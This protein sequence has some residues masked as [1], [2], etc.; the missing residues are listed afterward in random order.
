MENSYK[1]IIY[2]KKTFREI[3]LPIEKTSVVIGTEKHCDFRFNREFFFDSFEFTVKKIPNAAWQIRCGSNLYISDISDMKYT[4]KS[5]N[6]GDSYSLKYQS[7]NHEL[8]KIVF[9][10]NYD[11]KEYNFNR[12]IDLNSKK[13]ISF[14][15][16][17]SCNVCLSDSLLSNGKVATLKKSDQGWILSDTGSKHGVFIN[18]TKILR[19]ETV[20]DYD[21]FSILGFR[22]F[23]KDNILY[24]D[25]SYPL[26]LNSLE[27]F[28]V[29]RIGSS[30]VYPK[31]NRNTRLKYTVSTEK[32]PI[33]DPEKEPEKPKSNVLTS[34]LP[35]VA[36]LI[37]ILVIRGG[38][39]SGEG[40]LLS[41]LS[42]NSFIL[43]SAATMCLGMVT[44]VF[45]AI[46][47][48]KD[49]YKSLKKREHVYLKY[50]E[51]KGKEVD[52][53]RQQEADLLNDIYISLDEELQQVKD[54]SGDLFDKSPEDDDFLRV[55]LGLGSIESKRQ[56][57]YKKKE[58]LETS[59]SL[60]SK[61][62]DLY[63]E[64]K[65]V[66]N[67]PVVANFKDVNALGVVGDSAHL[68]Q[69]MKNMIVD[70]CVRHHYNDVK[71]FV[72]VEESKAENFKWV[73]WFQN[74]YN[75]KLDIR[76][77][78]CNDESKNLL[79]EYLYVE[80]SKRENEN[81][82]YPYTIVMVF[83]DVG[84]KLHP[85]S[86]YIQKA[87][88]FGFTFVFF[89]NYKE[90]LPQGC[91]EIILLN[92]E[93]GTGKLIPAK[94]VNSSVNFKYS[95]ISDDNALYISQRL[96]SVYCE[97]VSLEN[98][99]TKNITLFELLNIIDVYDLDL[100]KRWK[101]S[102]VSET[103][104]APLGVKTK[105]KIVSLDIHE[106]AHGPH[107][108]VAGT[109]GSGKSEILQTYILSM[110][111]LYHPYEVGFVIIDFKGGG[112]AN[113]FKNLPHLIG[114]ITNI[115]GREID[116][117]L[118]SIKAELEKRQI[119]FSEYDVNNINSYIKL[120]KSGKTSIP[121]PHLI[122]VVDEFAELKAEQ[123]EFMKELIS[124]ARI[125]RSL[126]VHLILATQKPA[127]QVNEQIWSNSKFKLCLK[128]QTKEDSNEVL[129]SPLAAEI[130]EPGRAYLQVGNN[131][132]F[133]LFQSAY[134]GAL[135]QNDVDNIGKEYTINCVELS[136]K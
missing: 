31:F 115:D 33:L 123:P 127:G 66:D 38:M 52:E 93:G 121:I 27:S 116:R 111:T 94:D 54:F 136:G 108:L 3:E 102:Q 133:E 85:V 98:A 11:L 92:G 59:D 120:F 91:Q 99:L 13:E 68:Y 41:N 126:G 61:P 67:V 112:M 56:I 74:I 28:P 105:N 18:T 89:E 132:I 90:L 124:A 122:I 46:M 119:L 40:S 134:S 117:S 39:L 21:F 6:H 42:E 109:T 23:L 2:N 14:G 5:F 12:Y 76:N 58:T 79:F 86:K 29:N 73:R 16:D 110:A 44:T 77:I 7:T 103:M 8:F 20:R 72:I 81:I 9:T 130:K 106:K 26:S 30:L 82:N 34:L 35:A 10:L 75:E 128:V 135:V 118:M 48:K 43:F 15:A 19:D 24:Y 84:I 1:L 60:I 101:T 4:S 125:G 32:I 47:N 55:R 71:L 83:D 50:I 113:Q 87:N 114:T 100:D 80:L 22:F 65:N 129:K 57:D 78:V 53:I 25:S 17:K 69:M 45:T 37:L 96:A 104:S 51:K 49:Y 88:Q 107:G 36:S 64:F 63:N 62:E 131:E 97:E 95:N 70:I